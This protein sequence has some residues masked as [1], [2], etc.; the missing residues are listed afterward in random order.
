MDNGDVIIK[1]GHVE[2]VEDTADGLR[3]KIRIP[4][5]GNEPLENLPY[6]FPLLPKTFQSVPKVGEG[7]LVFTQL[8]GNKMSQRYYIGPI[9]S[10]PQ[11]QEKCE[12]A[13]GRGNALSN[14]DGG[15]LEPLEKISNYRETFG[16]FPDTEDVA[17][18]GR[19]SQDIIMRNNYETT[20]NEVDV[21]CGIRN[22]SIYGN[23]RNGEAMAGKVV[24]NTLDPTYIQLK[25]KHSITTMP[26]QEANSVINM[27][28]DKIN[29]I[30]NK[31]EN[32]FNLTDYYELIKEDELDDIMSKLHQVPH[33][34]TLIKLLEI[35]IK[36]ILTH[37]HPYSGMPPVVS[38]YVKD[39]AEWLSK[40]KTIL[41]KHVRIS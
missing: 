26:E 38:G 33:G 29:I 8:S 19:G 25:Y 27:V 11:F 6:A 20:S 34:D 16:A 13:Y 10:Q 23:A 18:V 32:G 14:I 9:I 1:Q 7:A 2:Y 15:L 4:Q 5:D 24:F 21:R 35:M 36:A 41:S 17:M 30:S 40:L 22:D 39:S 3:I 28:A 37:V 12:Y 31:D